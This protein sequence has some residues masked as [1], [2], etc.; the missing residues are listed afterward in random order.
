MNRD[1]HVY[2]PHRYDPP[3]TLGRLRSFALV[4]GVVGLV[5]TLV[6]FFADPANLVRSYLVGLIFWITI[7]LGC[8]GLL[9]INHLTGGDWGVLGRRIFEAGA[10]TLPL[11]LVLFGLLYLFGLPSLYPWTLTDHHPADPHDAMEVEPETTETAVDG[12]LID[13]SVDT[14]FAP[15]GGSNDPPEGTGGTHPAEP[16][17]GGPGYQRIEEYVEKHRDFLEHKEPYLN[18]PFLWGRLLLY[19]GVWFVLTF[20]LTRLSARQDAEPRPAL[21]Q[22]MQAIS[23]PGLIL[24]A[25]TVSFAAYDWLM[26]LYPTWFSTMYGVYF[27][28]TMGLSALAFLIL[29]GNFLRRT[30]PWGAVFQA[31]IF[32]DYGKLL[33]AFVVLWAYFSISQF[34]IIWSG[35]LPDEIAWFLPRFEGG[36]LVV[37]TLLFV[38]HFGVPF[39]LLL[40]RDLKEKA[41]LLSWVAAFLLFM[42][43]VDLVWQVAPTIQALW[44]VPVGNIWWMAL[45]TTLLVGGI[46]MTAFL[47]LLDRRPLL[48]VNDP[49]LEEALVHGHA[50]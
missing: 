42:R 26:S 15:N 4:G 49:Y 22:R 27:I 39:V 48:P 35:N 12:T 14:G 7:P 1:P 16:G 24:L 45:G 38:F 8:L 20:F 19:V 31:R 5:L 44:N 2:D 18:I 30:E 9:M 25:L 13:P 50:H 41:K 46:W 17:H 47:F 23:A 32:H 3:A 40:S 36:W 11:F 33:L 34:L 6:G 29:V 10:K 21:T 28:G 43:F 37:T